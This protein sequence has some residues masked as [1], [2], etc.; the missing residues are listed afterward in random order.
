M[1][2]FGNGG[3]NARQ[4]EKRL[5]GAASATSVF[6]WL[7]TA[8]EKEMNVVQQERQQETE[9]PLDGPGSDSEKEGIDEVFSRKP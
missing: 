1:S 9:N 2:A 6:N 7:N 3:V 5:S 8:P 4:M